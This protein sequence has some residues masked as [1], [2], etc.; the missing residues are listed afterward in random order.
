[1]MNTRPIIRPSATRTCTP[2]MFHPLLLIFNFRFDIARVLLDTGRIT[3][4][5]SSKARRAFPPRLSYRAC[6]PEMTS[7]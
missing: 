2:R 5:V 1:M 4:N 7:G 3:S 6:A